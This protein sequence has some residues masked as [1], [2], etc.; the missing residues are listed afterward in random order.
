MSEDRD[1]KLLNVRRFLLMVMQQV[2]QLNQILKQSPF[3]QWTKVLTDH[4]LLFAIPQMLQVTEW[5]SVLKTLFSFPFICLSLCFFS[6][7]KN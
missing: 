7:N 1:R 2:E 3:G 6:T 5:K 4:E